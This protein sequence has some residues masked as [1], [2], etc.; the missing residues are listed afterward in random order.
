MPRVLA[1]RAPLS[2]GARAKI[3]L[4]GM[5][6]AWWRHD[7]T[8]SFRSGDSFPRTVFQVFQPDGSAPVVHN[9][10]PTLAKR[11]ALGQEQNALKQRKR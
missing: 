7:Q 10:D 9:F 2:S 1:H 11:A 6:A 8:P 5:K 4:P 3:F